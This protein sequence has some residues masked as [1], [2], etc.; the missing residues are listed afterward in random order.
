[1]RRPSP[2]AWAGVK[3]EGVAEH[4]TPGGRVLS[5]A[6]TRPRSPVIRPFPDREGSSMIKTSSLHRAAAALGACAL[7]APAGLIAVAD[8]AST[9]TVQ[10]KGQQFS[11]RSVTI[12]KN[13]R[14]TFKWA[15]GTH[16]LIGPKAH[17][18]PRSS[19]STTIRFTK[20]GSY[21]YLCS[22]HANMSMTVKVK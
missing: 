6:R 1:M 22:I 12:R 16:N 18:A 3:R 9:K 13:D 15:G 17:V 2:L 5:V 10:L 11:P 19:G 4:R 21:R 20:K 7:L 14:V 8:A